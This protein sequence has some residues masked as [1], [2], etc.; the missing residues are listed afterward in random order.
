M[1]TEFE[2]RA[3]QQC[4]RDL[5]DWWNRPGNFGRRHLEHTHVLQQAEN[6]RKHGEDPE[7][8]RRSRRCANTANRNI[9]QH[10]T[11]DDNCLKPGFIADTRDHQIQT[12]DGVYLKPRPST[13]SAAGGY[14]SHPS[15]PRGGDGGQGI[16]DP[17]YGPNGRAGMKHAF[18]NQRRA[19]DNY[20][21][22]RSQQLHADQARFRDDFQ[23]KRSALFRL[24]AEY[25]HG[26]PKYI[27]RQ[28]VP[29]SLGITFGDPSAHAALGQPFTRPGFNPY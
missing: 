9:S 3:R 25:P 22:H 21:N 29:Q 17:A 6:E 23:N 1:K 27:E 16:V 20:D 14:S 18:D 12:F 15:T 13:A 10:A 2:D 11:S 28:L 19:D 8:E 7:L 4:Q 5:D 26:I 24:A